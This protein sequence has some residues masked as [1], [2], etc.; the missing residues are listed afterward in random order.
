MYNCT[1]EGEESP[2][3]KQINPSYKSKPAWTNNL[4]TE[5]PRYI[6][7]GNYVFIIQNKQLLGFGLRHS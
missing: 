2:P 7:P 3:K 5:I 1:K 4:I 6:A